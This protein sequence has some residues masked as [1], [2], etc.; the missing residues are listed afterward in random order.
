MWIL[1]ERD[2]CA[3][4]AGRTLIHGSLG[5]SG[6]A[7]N[8]KIP[9]NRCNK[10]ASDETQGRNLGYRNEI[11]SVDAAAGFP[12]GSY[13]MPTKINDWAARGWIASVTEIIFDAGQMAKPA[14]VVQSIRIMARPLRLTEKICSR[15]MNAALFLINQINADQ[16]P[17]YERILEL[18]RI[19]PDDGGYKNDGTGCIARPTADV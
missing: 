7:L 2:W 13:C 8:R 11:H 19:H 9:A 14:S 6:L 17:D 1:R 3:S 16:V 10:F 4:A 18:H 12:A 5:R 15:S